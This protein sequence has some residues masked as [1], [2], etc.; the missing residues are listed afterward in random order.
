MIRKNPNLQPKLRFKD[1]NGNDFPDWSNR[2]VGEIFNV[3]RGNV[4]AVSMMKKYKDEN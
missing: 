3:T 1:E 4:L 2:K